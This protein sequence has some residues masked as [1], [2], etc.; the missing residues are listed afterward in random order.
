[1]TRAILIDLGGVLSEVPGFAEAWSSRLDISPE[2]FLRAVY[3]GSDEQVLIGAMSE[4][5]WWAIVAER[6]NV[7]AEVTAEIHR[8]IAA[9]ETWDD[10][11]VALL[12]DLHGRVRTAIVSNASPGTRARL[13]RDGMADLADELVISAEVGYAK[14]DPRI[15]EI[16]L[17]RVGAAPA[18][19]LF[20][21]DTPGHVDAA[22]ALGIVGHVHTDSAS[23]ITAIRDFLDPYS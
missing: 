8:D 20:I 14:P 11:L 15:F 16:A 12:R 5:D 19:A 21:D 3:R 1:M 13:A 4:A 17:R 23:T 9:R 6:L 18:D 22:R 7:T 2:A 10:E